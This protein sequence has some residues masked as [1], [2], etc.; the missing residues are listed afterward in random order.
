MR[1]RNC[2][3][4]YPSAGITRIRFKGMISARV[5]RHPI[6]DY[7]IENAKVAFLF[8]ATN[9]KPLRSSPKGRVGGVVLYVS[10]QMAGVWLLLNFQHIGDDLF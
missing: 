9:K 2:I 7:E 3:F 5:L 6:V 1:V 4:F 10:H 8:I